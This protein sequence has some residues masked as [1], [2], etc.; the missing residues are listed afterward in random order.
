MWIEET[1]HPEDLTTKNENQKYF[2]KLFLHF[3]E[4]KYLKIRS[5]K[6]NSK[7]LIFPEQKLLQMHSDFSNKSSSVLQTQENFI[8]N[9]HFYGHLKIN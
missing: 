3:F 7:K 6:I 4:D 1:S 2:E 9:R 8:K 5:K